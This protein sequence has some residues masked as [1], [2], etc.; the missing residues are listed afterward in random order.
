MPLSEQKVRAYNR[1]LKSVRARHQSVLQGME[2]SKTVRMENRTPKGYDAADFADA[3]KR[4]LAPATDSRHKRNSRHI[5]DNKTILWRM[6]RM[7]RIL[8]ALARVNP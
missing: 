3:W 2:K 5:F 8:E 6:W 4:Y 7:W 1:R